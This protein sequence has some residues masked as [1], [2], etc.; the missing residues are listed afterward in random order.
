MR[1]CRCIGLAAALAMATTAR[2]QSLESAQG[3]VAGLY[4]A[5][6]RSQPDYLGRRAASMF[7]PRLLGLI[8]VTNATRTARWRAT[9]AA[10]TRSPTDS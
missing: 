3:F 5:Y 2:A 8:G 6:Q 1:I 9:S 7:S 10:P 4:H